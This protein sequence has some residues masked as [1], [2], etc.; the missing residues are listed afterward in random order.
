MPYD[1]TERIIAVQP[2]AVATLFPALNAQYG[3]ELSYGSGTTRTIGAFWNDAE[4][5]SVYAASMERGSI[6]PTVLTDG[7]LAYRCLWQADLAAAFDA[8]EIE[9]VEE[10]TSEQ[11]ADLLVTPEQSAGGTPQ[12]SQ[13]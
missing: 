12:P 5:T 1:T 13:P 11:L 6:A 3:E 4:Q 2:E 10:L 7:R 8:G 9:G